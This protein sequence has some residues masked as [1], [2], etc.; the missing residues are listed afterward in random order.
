MTAKEYRDLA[1]TKLRT[2]VYECVTNKN[3][4]VP[5]ARA[6]EFVDYMVLA[7]IKGLEEKLIPP[8]GE[9]AEGEGEFHELRG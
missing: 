2:L 7:S 1:A 4:M 3:P 5:K 8:G 6:E 9:E